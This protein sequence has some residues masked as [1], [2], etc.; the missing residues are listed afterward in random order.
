MENKLNTVDEGTSGIEETNGDD[1]PFYV[2]DDEK[3]ALRFQVLGI[4]TIIYS[5]VYGICLYKNLTGIMTPVFTI[6]TVVYLWLVLPGLSADMASGKEK[7]KKLIPYFAGIVLL[8]ISVFMTSDM[9]IIFWNYVGIIFLTM[10]ALIRFF[11]D[12]A[13]WGVWKYMLAMLEI[14]FA[15][16]FHSHMFFSDRKSCKVTGN[17]KI[18]INKNVKYVIIG[19]IAAIP[20]LIVVTFLLA[21][22]DVIFFSVVNGVFDTFF[23][24]FHI[25][26]DAVGFIILI[27][28]VLLIVY[29]LIA[30]LSVHGAAEYEL[31]DKKCNPITGITFCGALTAVYLLYSCI[32]ILSLFMGERMM[33]EWHSYSSYA[34]EG[35]YQLLYVAALNLFIVLVCNS[36]FTKHRVLKIVL[37]IMCGCTYIMIASSAIRLLMYVKKYNLTY[38]RLLALFALLLIAALMAGIIA[39]IYKYDFRLVRYFIA[40]TSVL[41]I[42]L[43]FAH[44]DYIIAKYDISHINTVQSN[45]FDLKYLVSNMS[46]DAAPAMYAFAEEIEGHGYDGNASE[47]TKNDMYL[48]SYFH[49]VSYE[50]DKY[51]GIREFNFSRY[52]AYLYAERYRD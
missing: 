6:A 21:S 9:F 44:P 7:R 5:I 3:S 47:N 52:R 43:S 51:D 45:D 19:I 28:C 25:S 36:L 37:T 46:C 18:K 34:R 38:L 22:A 50:Y 41:Y 26:W 15:P 11:Y 24:S 10:T 40:V 39:S 35:F 8:G 42:A 17:T 33:L 16:L 27:L 48:Q 31:T 13:D 12:E 29:G 32:Q 2:R 4:P 30:M 1:K 23:N 20:F 49:D 14:A